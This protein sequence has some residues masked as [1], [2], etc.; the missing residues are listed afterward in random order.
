MGQFERGIQSAIVDNAVA[1]YRK[2]IWIR[3]KHGDGYAVVGD[4]DLYGCLDGGFFGMEVKNEEGH[5][6]K[7]QIHRIKEILDAG[8][9]AAGVRSVEE[10]MGFFIQWELWEV[11]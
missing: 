3:V 5:L 8:G 4:P 9:N 6:T 11:R 1:R 2:R 7:I 10:A